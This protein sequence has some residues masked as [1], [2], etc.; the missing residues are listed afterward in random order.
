MSLEAKFAALSV[1]D[2]SFV[3]DTVKS[4]G[5]EKSGLAANVSVLAARCGS[6]DDKEALGAMK[7]VK[8]LAESGVTG[9]QVF[10][11]ECLGACK[12][13]TFAFSQHCYGTGE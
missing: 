12:Y 1:D 4:E 6:A 9:A 10:T 3:V 11:K 2:A 13:T 8:A 7:T 5:V